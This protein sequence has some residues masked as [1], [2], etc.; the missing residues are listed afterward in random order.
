MQTD[1]KEP[2][3]LQLHMVSKCLMQTKP[4]AFFF[5]HLPHILSHSFL[6]LH[7][8]HPVKGREWQLCLRAGDQAGLHTVV[9][10]KR[11]QDRDIEFQSF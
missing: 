3:L 1:L 9:C 2:K 4:G 5:I 7:F 6:I 10:K 11:Q 8:L